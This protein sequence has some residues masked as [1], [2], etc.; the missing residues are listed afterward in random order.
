[1]GSQFQLIANIRTGRPR[2]IPPEEYALEARSPRDGKGRAL[3]SIAGQQD[4]QI[5]GLET[6]RP[7]EL[8]RHYPPW[9]NV[10][11]RFLRCSP[12]FRLH[13]NR[14]SAQGVPIKTRKA[15]CGESKALP[16]SSTTWT[17]S[18]GVL[19]VKQCGLLIWRR[20]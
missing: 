4:S 8:P 20:R 18:L 7:P 2:A 3:A 19:V 16:H 12:A 14:L 1:M 17:S 6:R 5:G 10:R 13:A 15:A 11:S 9:R